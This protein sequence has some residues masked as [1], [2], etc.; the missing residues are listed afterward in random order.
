MA[1]IRSVYSTCAAAVVAAAL[2]CAAR[3]DSWSRN[4][5]ERLLL[6]WC[7]ALLAREVKGM[8]DPCLDG[9]LLCPACNFEHGRSAD[10]VYAL[11][12]EWKKTGDA[13]YIKAAERML[14]WTE[15]NFVGC[16]GSNYNDTKHYWR[17]ITVFSQISLGKT[18]LLCG[19]ALPASFR[20]SAAKSFRRQTEYI[21]SWLAP[22][23]RVEL[24]TANI[25]YAVAFCETI[26]ESG[27]TPMLYCNIRWF[28]EKLDITRIAD[29][30]KW[31][32]QYFRKPFF[33]YAFQ[34]WQYSSSGAVDGI[35]GNVDFN[36]S[37]VDYGNL[38]EE[39]GE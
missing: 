3:A 31:F 34:V 4:D 16:D 19:D 37:F 39:S 29:Y 13:K 25:N 38:P 5:A 32:A 24:G 28:I 30:D 27:Y 20:E 18:M 21:I 17:G 7:D 6:K 33:P 35:S 1:D 9:G 22:D 11:A 36:I 23:G 15:R 2:S 12:Y 14:D 8:G 26:K 10:A